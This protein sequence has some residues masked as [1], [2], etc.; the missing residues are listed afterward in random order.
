MTATERHFDSAG[1]TI[2]YAES[3]AGT[4]AVLV[5]SFTGTFEAQFV[6]T[7]LV[8]A[9]AAR[10]RVIGFDLRGHG[11]SGKPHATSAYGREMALDIVRLLDHLAIERAHV[12]GYSLVAH[13]VAQ[14]MTL[15]PERMLSAVLGGSCGRR[16][17]TADDDRRIEREAGELERGLLV[18]QIARLWPPGA[19]RPT[20]GELRERSRVYLAGNDPLAL[21]AIRRSN[22]D[23][24]VSATEMDR[25]AVPVLGIVGGADP[26]A[27]SFQS[28]A[29]A[30]PRFRFV[31]IDGATHNGAPSRPEFVRAVLEFLR[32]N[33]PRP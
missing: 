5:H 2:R 20:D 19:P 27:S 12:V 28:L 1:V 11:G 8:D 18:A 26:Y 31:V 3:G 9:L 33:D 21:A 32:A 22:R 13:I 4:P 25:S 6:R 7:G 30:M 29:Q 15:R 10:Y 24:R 23:Q 14:L 16:E 17:W